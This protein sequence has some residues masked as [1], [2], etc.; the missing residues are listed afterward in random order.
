[1][2]INFGKKLVS[3]ESDSQKWILIDFMEDF[4]N[5]I[6]LKNSLWIP[7]IPAGLYFQDQKIN[8]S[9]F[10]RCQGLLRFFHPR[11]HAGAIS[12]QPD[13][14]QNFRYIQ[15]LEQSSENKSV[16]SMQNTTEILEWL[17]ARI[18]PLAGTYLVG[19]SVRDGLAG[20]PVADLDV[21]V[22]ENPGMYATA[23]ADREKAR[24]VPIGKP[25]KMIHRVVSKTI[26]V[27]IAEIQGA[28]IEEDLARRDFTI[29]AMALSLETG[30]L[31]DTT[32][33]RE[34]LAAGIV[35]MVTE[36]VFR[37]DPVRLLRGYRFAAELNFQIHP[38]TAKA[39]ALQRAKIREAA[40]ERIWDELGKFLICPDTHGHLVRMSGTGLL[41]DLIPELNPLRGCRQ[42]RHH[43]EDVFAH[44]L[45]T[46]GRLEKLLAGKIGA[47]P[48]WVR[49]RN[50]LAVLKLAALLYDAGKPESKTV[51]EDG[52]IHFYEHEK[53]GAA[54][55]SMTAKRLRLSKRDAD[56]LVFLVLHHMRPRHLFDHH[57]TDRPSKRP[58]A[59]F[60]RKSGNYFPELIL[61]SAADVLSHKDPPENE[62]LAFWNRIFEDYQTY[63]RPKALGPPLLD[64][65]DLIETFQLHPAPIFR[66]L[67]DAVEEARL[68]GDIRTREEA[69][70]MV[71]RLLRKEKTIT[72]S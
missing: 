30:Q 32:G 20:R 1:M 46:F 41:F 21:A 52:E 60:F 37:D 11:R 4:E 53:K 28:S 2:P 9:C 7:F 15:R 6:R 65:K 24:V 33:G 25:G 19:G 48:S 35:S 54:L 26:W 61:L 44:T 67:L 5:Q 70:A 29:N 62:Y 42:G 49:K 47:L 27:D 59:R 66:P 64:G 50:H 13:A 55:A 22:R 58:T 51:A 23:L 56:L 69:L 63:Y 71:E 68:A 8:I 17:R 10:S 31:I 57:R 16:I 36:H 12:E 45:R 43:R 18:A 39:I 3:P 72:P 38:E 34:D 40:A 14:I